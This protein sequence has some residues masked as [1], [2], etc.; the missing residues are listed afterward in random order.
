MRQV[1]SV[2]N[3]A[4]WEDLRV[5]LAVEREG[6]FHAAAQSLKMA[7]STV[8]RRVSLLETALGRVLV[9]R[10][11]AGTR[12]EPDAM[13]LV[14]AAARLE[15]RLATLHRE[16]S[17]MS[18]VVRLSMGE[19]FVL[20]V[21]RLLAQ[22]QR[23]HSDLQIELVSESRVAHIGRREADIA[24]RKVKST[25]A[26]LVQK[27]VG[28]LR[29][30]LFASP[31]YLQATKS[32]RVVSASELRTHRFVGYDQSGSGYAQTRW[33]ATQGITDVVF[34]ANSDVALQTAT[35]AGVGLCLLGVANGY[36]LPP[37]LVQLTYRGK[38]PEVPLFL[39]WRKELQKVPRIRLVTRTLELALRKAFAE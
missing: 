30:R 21:T 32:Q 36:E 24:L 29:F 10:T 19:G 2:S 18:G 13:D 25:E 5:L 17:S 35:E 38:L 23:A 37:S 31:A 12:V 27:R 16:G 26:G 7:T 3:P 34:R 15:Q 6:S 20:P 11:S 33:L 9:Q 4:N 8:A 14:E 28:T 39:V 22:L 1:T